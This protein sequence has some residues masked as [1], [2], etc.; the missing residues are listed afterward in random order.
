MEHAQKCEQ[1]KQ[2]SMETRELNEKLE[3]DNKKL[4]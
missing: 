4:A 3:R 2:K 1:V